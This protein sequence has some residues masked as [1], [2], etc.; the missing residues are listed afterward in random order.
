[1]YSPVIHFGKFKGRHISE[2]SEDDDLFNWIEQLSHS[3]NPKSA[4]VGKW[5]L[6]NLDRSPRQCLQ[7]YLDPELNDLQVLIDGAR[8]QL[9]DLDAAYTEEHQAVESIRSKLFILLRPFYEKRDDLLIKVNYR[10]RFLD[11]LMRDDKGAAETIVEEERQASDENHQNYQQAVDD[12]S[13]KHLLS[14][15]EQAELREIYRR[16]AALYHPDR[17]GNDPSKQA[18]FAELMKQINQAKDSGA[19]NILREIAMDPGRFLVSHGY[20]LIAINDESGVEGL[21]S[22]LQLL[23]NKIVDSRKLL[24]DL[25]RSSGYE[26]WKLCEQDPDSL[27]VIAKEQQQDL[28]HEIRQLEDECSS[29]AKQI[30]ELAGPNSPYKV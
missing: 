12:A 13:E 18:A 10:R 11:A 28:E 1:M 2:A 27:D 4:E 16:L 8:E 21:Q 3:P 5:Y 20:E 6:A 17:Y 29:L 15:E 19:I 30:N 9:A 23:N 7:V 26:L 24:D 14:S 22:L 25:R